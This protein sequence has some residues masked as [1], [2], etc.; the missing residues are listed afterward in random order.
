MQAFATNQSGTGDSTDTSKVTGTTLIP[1]APQPG[2]RLGRAGMVPAISRVLIRV[3]PSRAIGD[4]LPSEPPQVTSSHETGGN[5]DQKVDHEHGQRPPGPWDGQI[6]QGIQYPNRKRQPD[7][8]HD[9][10]RHN[11]VARGSTHR[12]E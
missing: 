12:F 3:P 2:T 6:P 10:T 5:R 9:E 7:G 8:N 11:Q 4:D 1:Y